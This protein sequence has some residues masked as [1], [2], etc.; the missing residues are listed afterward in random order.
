M[1]TFRSIEELIRMLSREK[2]L[3]MDMF[4]NRKKVSYSYDAAKELVDY[5]LERI[6]FLIEHG[7]IHDSGE[8]LELEDVYL[9]FFEEVMDVNEDISVAGVQESIDALNSAIEY[10]LVETS[11]QRKFT[12]LKD[13]KR[14]LRNIALTTFRNLIDLKR[15]IDNTY[16]NEPN[17][18]VK[19][20]KLQKLDEKRLAVSQLIRRTEN[21]LDNRQAGFFAIAMDVSLNKTVIDVR[22]Q[23]IEAYHNLMELD[24]QIIE[25][26][27]LIDYNNRLVEKLRK[28]KY[29]RDQLVLEA[30]TD[31]RN[32][33]LNTNPVWME[34]R[35][36]YTLK[37]SL[38]MLR[39]SDEGLSALKNLKLRMK[40]GVS[41]RKRN[42]E[43]IPI[44]FLHPKASIAQG[45]NINELKNAFLASGVD[46]YSFIRDY[47]F[48]KSEYDTE[49]D[50]KQRLV[51][52]CQIAS[53]Y[54]NQ[55]NITNRYCTDCDVEYPLI[56]PS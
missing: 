14:I 9:K 1:T 19:R 53:Q 49:P 50:R 45:F 26:L 43:A 41:L 15:N 20:L 18:R 32:M 47:D 56:F 30:V 42:A 39:C 6:E 3:L 24:R 55:L 36:K 16:K 48:H 40:K 54:L 29:L 44:E 2:A 21:Y 10:Y 28:V 37:L 23:L 27:N 46:L 12:Y 8:F 35:P 17:Y 52:F 22:Q 13:V 5:K 11:A 25:Y 33:L 4:S 38:E 31:V 51:I 7:V 34:N